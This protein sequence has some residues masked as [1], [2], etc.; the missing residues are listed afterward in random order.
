[1]RRELEWA[2]HF[3][4]EGKPRELHTRPPLLFFTDGA[5]EEN[6]SCG[7]VGAMMVDGEVAEHFGRKVPGRMM[8]ALQRE[9]KRIIA[10][11]EIMPVTLA[12]KLWQKRLEHRR[13]F[14]FVDNDAAR[15]SL[16]K[17]STEV[18]AMKV[19]LLRLAELLAEVPCF[20]WFARVASASNP[21]DAPSR[22]ER[23]A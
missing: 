4:R 6:D 8:E 13:V 19:M 7:T 18:A 14:V 12:F 3:R 17:M 22:L 21:G 5:L 1:M 11:L 9:T 10:V 2:L 16:I 23:R 20:P 15:A